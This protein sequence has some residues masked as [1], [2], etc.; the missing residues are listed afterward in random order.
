M[1]RIEIRR[2]NMIS[3]D[4]LPHATP[5]DL[6]YDSGEFETIMDMCLDRAD[7]AGYAA[8]K[9]AS[10]AA[11]KRR[12][13][14]IA[15]YLETTAGPGTELA[16]IRFEEDGSVTLVT[17]NKDFGM[18]HA[19]PFAQVLSAQLGI[20][21][22]AINLVQWDSDEMSEGAGG[23]GGSRSMI[24]ASGAIVEC[25][26]VIIDNGKKFA[27]HVLE[28]A[29]EDIEFANGVFSVAGTDR[30]IGIIS[31]AEKARSITGTSD[32]LPDSLSHKVNHNT[33]P[34]SFPNGCHVAEIEIDPDTG[35]IGIDRYT[36]VD[37]F[38]VVVNP[39]IVEGQV[40]GGIAQGIG[41]V[42][43]EDTVYDADG[44]LLT[45]TY[46]DYTLPRADEIAHIDFTTH[47][48][49]CKTNPLGVKGCGEAGNGGAYPVIYNAIMDAIDG[50][51]GKEI[52]IPATP[53]RIWQ[54]LN[55]G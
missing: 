38:G 8:R 12:G 24:A 42:L 27:G 1:D 28:A 15:P 10:E 49:P 29:V 20:P 25:S 51:G 30:N 31:L 23:S 40:H 22:E 4:M 45:G 39:L 3:P 50:N 5:V 18:G 43:F 14:G 2:R 6:T 55:A 13:I 17:G 44:Q 26:G 36:V 54:A 34:I 19:T 35:D 11:G 7:Y 16:D 53:H 21:F 9:Q 41:Q 47:A 37:D 33:A 32:D 52:G 46:M 48:V